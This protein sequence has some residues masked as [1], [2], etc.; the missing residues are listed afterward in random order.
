MEPID[1]GRL[2]EYLP[3]LP[4]PAQAAIREKFA[5]EGWP[6]LTEEWESAALLDAV[7]AMAEAAEAAGFV[8]W[9][10]GKLWS[11]ATV[12]ERIKALPDDLADL[13]AEN[14]GQAGVP[15]MLFPERWA[16]S[17][18]TA[19]EECLLHAEGM[20]AKRH[21]HVM[22]ALGAA[23]EMSDDARHE[24]VRTVTNGR[25]ESSKK[26]TG[27]EARHLASWAETVAIAPASLTPFTVD[28]WKTEAKRLQTTLG[29]LSERAK[30]FNRLHQLPAITDT[31]SKALK[32]IT[33]DNG[34][35]TVPWAHR[36][37]AHLLQ[38]DANDDGE[39]MMEA[40][41]AEVATMA[42]PTETPAEVEPKPADIAP[43]MAE[44]TAEMHTINE[45]AKEIIPQLTTVE[46]RDMVLARLDDLEA[47][48][49]TYLANQRLMMDAVTRILS[50][51]QDQG[52]IAEDMAALA[53]DVRPK[54]EQASS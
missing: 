33:D 46:D 28:D 54:L 11:F 6:K 5:A 19:L 10:W 23:A 37:I 16:P 52:K 25:T 50:T 14:A 8:N 40:T 53:A 4:P 21:R 35:A 24:A 36:T 44:A 27:P 9:E 38:F 43:M 49:H 3:T 45:C 30:T 26:L 22:A 42:P 47:N 41:A 51:L 13:A 1:R 18:W 17:H 7:R 29:D 2:R 34:G 31:G 48:Q 20:A 15:S 12:Q 39:T 32:Q